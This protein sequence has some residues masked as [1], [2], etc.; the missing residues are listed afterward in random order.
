MVEDSLSAS[1]YEGLCPLCEEDGD[2]LYLGLGVTEREREVDEEREET[3]LKR[4]Q[5]KDDWI[6]GDEL[7]GKG[8][9][10]EG[11]QN[12][13][14]K[15]KGKEG[16]VE[17]KQETTVHDD[18][19]DD[20][21]DD[22]G[23]EGEEVE[24]DKESRPEEQTEVKK[25]DGKEGLSSDRVHQPVR[26]GRV[27]QLD[28]GCPVNLVMVCEESVERCPMG[29][30]QEPAL[31][32]VS[33]APCLG[34]RMY[35]SSPSMEPTTLVAPGQL[36]VTL[37][38]VY[39]TR[40][41]TRFSGQPAQQQPLPSVPPDSS[42]QPLAY[43]TSSP[44]QPAAPK[45]KIRT[46]YT[47]DQLEELERVFQDDHYP[48]AEKRK[49]IAISVGVTPQRV[50]VW[51]QNRRAKWRKISKA[52]VKK[53]PESRP[54][55]PAPV[56]R[57]PVF[58]GPAF[59]PL[60]PQTGNA[61]P[62]YSTLFTNSRSP[63]GNMDAG[64]ACVSHG[65]SLDYIPPVMQSP[66][67]LRRASLPYFAAY[68]PPTHMLSVLLDTSEHSEPQV[69]SLHTDHGFDYDAA[70]SSTRHES[71]PGNAQPFPLNTCTQ[72][73]STLLP[74]QPN[75]LFA[76]R[77]DCFVGQSHPLLP[78]YSRLSYFTPSPYLTPSPSEGTT[79]ST[80]PL[81][82]GTSSGLLAC[83]TGGHAYFQYPNSNQ[84]LLQSGVQ[85]FQAYAW[86]GDACGHSGQF[87][88]AVLRPQFTSQSHEGHYPPLLP[89]Q[90]YAV[91]PRASCPSLS[92]STPSDPMLNSTKPE[93]E[94]AAQ[95][96]QARVSEAETV[97]HCD[98]S[99]IHF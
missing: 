3:E 91:P 80:V 86:A 5:S 17:E 12:G 23:H 37:R 56:H 57:P 59:A 53:P 41:Y 19:D 32:P 96:Q 30:T 47:T 42:T 40:C 45:K 64:T 21:G 76:G 87:P 1:D 46:S 95:S 61:L 36:E 74:Q 90:H 29:Q 54:M 92:K 55:A 16:M 6:K 68:N 93:L 38:Q 94:D 20:D 25:G 84:I 15:E 71:G 31:I 2:G 70:G 67:P 52:I 8:I 48:D 34:K 28:P 24:M 83:S 10:E 88:P 50:M 35:G 77:S 26:E 82:P 4:E 18:D 51:F 14:K 89:P 78:Q 22:Y 65:G 72:Q 13:K 69:L 98:F 44:L 66:P 11:K 39:T 7:A 58:P 85:A 81:N 27:L 62:P 33:E 60:P 9:N 97:F 99:P 79:A 63:P 43:I 73:H 49:E 75:P